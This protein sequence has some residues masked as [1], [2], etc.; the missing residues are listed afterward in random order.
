MSFIKQM[1]D[2]RSRRS[3]RNVFHQADERQKKSKSKR[4]V[5]HQADEGHKELE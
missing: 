2:K 4:N 1:K 5:L 3:K